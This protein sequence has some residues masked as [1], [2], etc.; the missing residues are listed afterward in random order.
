MDWDLREKR[1][2]PYLETEFFVGLIGI[3]VNIRNGVFPHHAAHP[4]H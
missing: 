1:G 2:L 4:R 3:N